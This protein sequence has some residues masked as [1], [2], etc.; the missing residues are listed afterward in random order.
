MLLKN[1]SVLQISSGFHSGDAVSNQINYLNDIFLEFNCKTFFYNTPNHKFDFNAVQL[2]SIDEV[3]NRNFC[4]I[5]VHYG[6][7][8]P[9]AEKLPLMS[10][11]KILFYHNF[12]PYKYFE[13]YNG[14]LAES[15]KQTSEQLFRINKNFDY[16][17]TPSNYNKS[18]LIEHNFYN[19]NIYVVPYLI[20]C[21]FSL[22][23]LL[24]KFFFPCGKPL[25]ILYTG[26]IEVHKK[27]ENIIEFFNI[28]VENY[29]FDCELHLTGPYDEN[30]EYYFELKRKVKHSGK[31]FFHGR[32]DYSEIYDY[33]NMADIYI[34]L[35]E[36]EGFCIP[37]IEAISSFL[38]VISNDI[39]AIREN[40]DGSILFV[41]NEDYHSISKM[42]I[43]IKNNYLYRIWIIIRQLKILDKFVFSEIK[44]KI[45]TLL[46]NLTIDNK[47]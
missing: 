24:K 5:I 6:G 8:F 25:K 11:K 22:K 45:K 37:V 30:S 33:F 41:N 7:Y 26:R 21:K 19:R 29:Y 46:F 31:V 2:N 14:N 47:K 20:K 13:K 32:K 44:H 17:I 28:L 36:H 15:L 3:L 34:N 18:S 16:A 23:N 43:K 27:I 40:T 38:P 39:P 12:T 9:E 1:C 4:L 35:S 42:V 10:G